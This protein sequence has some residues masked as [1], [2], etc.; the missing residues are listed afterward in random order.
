MNYSR[1]CVAEILADWARECSMSTLNYTLEGSEITIY[2]TK[3]GYLIGERGATIEKYQKKFDDLT[4]RMNNLVDKI[5]M[6]QE[7]ID[8]ELTSTEIE[9]RV[10]K[11]KITIVEVNDAAVGAWYNQCQNVFSRGNAV[12]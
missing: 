5:N 7:A 10:D 12:L 4:N 3:P 8:T 11:I 1:T 6:R 2:A 9:E